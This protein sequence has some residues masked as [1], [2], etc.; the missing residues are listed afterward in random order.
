M[1]PAGTRNIFM[2][3]CAVDS[4]GYHYIYDEWP[5]HET[6]GAW[7][8]PSASERKWDGDPGP[9]QATLGHGVVDYKRLILER[10]GNTFTDG[11]WQ[12]NG[13]HIHERYIDP[14]SGRQETVAENTG[15][16]SMIDRFGEEQEDYAGNLIGPSL[17]FVPAPG[18]LEGEG[19]EAINTKLAYDQTQPLVPLLNEPKLYVTRNC[20]NLIWALQNY[21][22]HDGEKAACKDPID[23]LRYLCTADLVYLPPNHNP[24]AHPGGSY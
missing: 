1:D 13:H 5:D 12:M 14:R 20:Q 9:A 3:W 23:C 24:L 15:G 21:T 18:L 4:R 16:M 17:D 6:M 8:V 10:E 19:L 2:L 22:G 7:A 11:T